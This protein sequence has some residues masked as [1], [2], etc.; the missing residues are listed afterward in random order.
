MTQ[1]SVNQLS[2]EDLFARA[3]AWTERGDLAQAEQLLLA[4]INEGT[5]ESS[6]G[7]SVRARALLAEVYEGLG[8]YHDAGE[9][10]ALYDPHALEQFSPHQR[11]LLLLAFGSHA[12]WEN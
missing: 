5:V 11:G 10:L 8:R 7:R 3:R 9:V 2:A 4:L 6:S 12:Y 1:T